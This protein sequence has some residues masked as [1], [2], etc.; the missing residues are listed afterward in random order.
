MAENPNTV[1]VNLVPLP[2]DFQISQARTGDGTLWVRL[3]C[4]TPAGT[5]A[6]FLPGE[7]AEE[8]GQ[9]LV[10]L[11]RMTKA[12]LINPSKNGG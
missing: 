1:S 4:T 10:K 5:N 3:V 2:V 12:G 8:F 11:G 7:A 9:A 6:Y